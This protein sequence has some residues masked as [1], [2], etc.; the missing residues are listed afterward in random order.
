MLDNRDA[1]YEALIQATSLK[2]NL[3]QFA[4][5]KDLYVTKAI[6]VLMAVPDDTFKLVFQGGTALAKAHN[7]IERMSEDCDF[8]LAYKVPSENRKKDAQR[9]LLRG[10]R[11]NLLKALSENGFELAEDAV[12]VRNEGQ[13]ISM[14]A[15]YVSVYDAPMSLKP[16]LALEF[17]LGQ[18]KT[19][20]VERTVTSLIRQTLGEKIAHPEVSVQCMSI[21]ETAA[22][23][24]VALTRRVATMEQR[25]HYY[26]QA[27]VRHI[28]DLTMINRNHPLKE[29]DFAKLVGEIVEGDRQHFKTHS[30]I[31]HQD[32]IKAIQHALHELE[33]NPMWR[34]NWENFMDTMVYGDKPTYEDAMK[35]LKSISAVAL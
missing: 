30:D 34:E 33:H 3:S 29:T 24:W 19:P 6:S 32:P 23:K 11:K 26:D 8:R 7:Y 20:T 9:K 4:I 2:L 22:E 35:V 18:V 13:F 28:Y 1:Q 31:F 14:R 5:E 25:K 27:L 17:F 10:F 21:P 16:Y 12:R 15:R